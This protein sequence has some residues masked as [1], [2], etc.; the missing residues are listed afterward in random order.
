M[1]RKPKPTALKLLEGTYR[2]DRDQPEP[3][4]DRPATVPKPPGWL[5]E[6]AATEWRRVAP[7][8]MRLG[9]LANL[10]LTLLAAYCCA[11]SRLRQAEALIQQHGLLIPGKNREGFVI[12][13]RNAATMIARESSALVAS[14]GAELGIGASGRT[15]LPRMRV[16]DDDSLGKFLSRRPNKFD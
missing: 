5:D 9:V 12:M 2:A 13:K 10:V 8:L 7:E 11:V 16:H 6:I 1:S 14:L 15:R 4:V 3:P